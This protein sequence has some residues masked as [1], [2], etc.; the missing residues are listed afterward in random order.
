MA[1]PEMGISV[2][3]DQRLAGVRSG[4]IARYALELGDALDEMLRH[5][6]P[7][8]SSTM[9]IRHRPP[10][11]SG[12]EHQR[13]IASN[14]LLSASSLRFAVIR[15]MSITPP[16]S[17]PREWC[18]VRSSLPSTILPSCA[19]QITSARTHLRYYRQIVSQSRRTAHWITPSAWTRSELVSL[20]GIPEEDVTV[21]PH[22][23][24][25][26]VDRGETT[27]RAQRKPYLL[28]I[29]TIEPRKRYDLLLDAFERLAPKPQLYVVGTPGWN[30]DDIQTRLR[31]TEGVTWLADATD[32][33]INEL[34]SGA[35]A[36]AVP[37]LAEGFGLGMLEAMARGNA[38][39]FIR[40]R[41][42]ERGSGRR[43]GRADRRFAGIMGRGARRG[44][45][46]SNTLDGMR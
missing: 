34:L 38:G 27:P 30:T 35:L 29:G 6:H 4:G 41:R 28:A 16:I 14:Q 19:G 9:V 43:S 10:V 8:A 33:Q 36:L 3:L 15:S 2:G 46:R 45:A 20:V 12:Y 21:V 44:H 40:P 39:R 26:F 25:T 5:W 32:A 24:S 18:A 31:S 22:G 7:D 13:I 37:S 17:S 1:A 11:K 42:I 23:V